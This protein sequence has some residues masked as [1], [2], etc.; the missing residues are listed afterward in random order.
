M[1]AP[2]RNEPTNLN[3]WFGRK[4]RELREALGW[5]QARL[6]EE[7]NLSGGRIAQFERAEDVPPKD[8]TELLDKALGAG[9]L[10]M[11]LRPLLTRSW[12]EKWPEDI[13]DIEEQATRIQQFNYTIPA[14]FQTPEY[15][16]AL[17][18]A[19]V[20]FVGGDLAEKVKLRL[21]RRDVVDG[22]SHP[23]LRC[24]VDESALYR[25]V[26]PP[27]I[28]RAQLLHL[29]KE[30]EEPR[31][32]VQVLPFANSRMVVPGMGLATIWTLS[33][34]RTLAYQETVDSGY[35]VTKPS[36]VSLYTSLFDQ[37][38]ADAL[39][40]DASLALIR[41]VLEDRYS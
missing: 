11:E 39:P 16:M 32:T 41:R 28:M 1:P 17:L 38:Q 37:F 6:G 30:C 20:P 12:E 21:S 34:G 35:F 8:I 5:T 3:E 23:W 7:V 18:G 13:C 14:F 4:I 31:V 9:G 25:A 15:A 26:C 10:L 2:K 24:V 27:D 29:L 36:V 22:L 40:T 19:G 33:D